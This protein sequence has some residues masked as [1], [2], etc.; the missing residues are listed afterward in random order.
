MGDNPFSPWSSLVVCD[1]KLCQFS[2]VTKHAFFYFTKPL[3]HIA[4]RFQTLQHTKQKM[5]QSWRL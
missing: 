5:N 4:S 3:F 2:E 1:G